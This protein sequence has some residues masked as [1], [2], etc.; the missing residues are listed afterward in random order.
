MNFPPHLPQPSKLFAR[1]RNTVSIAALFVL[2][3]MM[4]LTAIAGTLVT[5]AWIVPGDSP[6]SITRTIHHVQAPEDNTVSFEPLVEQQVRQRRF[7]IFDSRKKLGDY[8]PTDASIGQAVVVNTQGWAALPR[9]SYVR[10]QEQFWDV[11]TFLGEKVVIEKVIFD[12]NAGLVYFL[13]EGN[14]HRGDVQ[15]YDWGKDPAGDTFIV[16]GVDAVRA[17]A[18][19]DEV[20]LSEQVPHLLSQRRFGHTVTGE[21]KTGDMLFSTGG[22]FAGFINA[23]RVVV[24]SWILEPQLQNI[25]NEEA[26]APF[27]FDA[28]GRFV[29]LDKHLGADA[30]YGFY[31]QRNTAQSLAAGILV[32]DVITSVSG[33]GVSER[34]ASQMLHELNADAQLQI[35]R[36]EDVRLIELSLVQE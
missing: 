13:A 34:N 21:V 27:V 30:E 2:L 6:A 8:Y 32:G 12:K 36:G 35:L 23:Q 20:V 9:S 19:N 1:S 17:V 10:G 18:I 33:S 25:F 14:E 29:R 24:P 28:I 4:F 26:L 22:N 31:I 5:I 7:V 3:G 11:R 16:V 15:F